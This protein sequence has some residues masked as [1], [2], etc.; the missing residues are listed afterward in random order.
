MIFLFLRESEGKGASKSALLSKPDAVGGWCFLDAC[1]NLIQVR[2]L[3]AGPWGILH[4]IGG[5]KEAGTRAHP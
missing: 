3:R 5:V 2:K 4:F 1:A